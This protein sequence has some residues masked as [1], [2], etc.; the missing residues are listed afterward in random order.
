MK[1]ALPQVVEF[2]PLPN[3]GKN[4]TPSLNSGG[5]QGLEDIGSDVISGLALRQF[6]HAALQKEGHA[7]PLGSFSTEN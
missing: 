3:W 6:E 2:S 5:G 4:H 7:K 1:L